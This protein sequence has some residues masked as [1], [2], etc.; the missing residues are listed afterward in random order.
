MPSYEKPE[1][2]V[3]PLGTLLLRVVPENKH[4]RK[5]FTHLAKLIPITRYGL[6]KWMEDQRVPPKRVARLVEIS[7]LDSEGKKIDKPRAA[8]EDFHEYV[9]N[10]D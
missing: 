1:D 8:V 9:F 5:T 10:F 7:A 6:Q 2:A 3:T 4:G